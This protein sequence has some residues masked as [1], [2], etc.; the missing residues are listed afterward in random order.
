MGIMWTKIATQATRNEHRSPDPSR[1]SL[2]RVVIN[3]R[4]C[5]FG[6]WQENV[7]CIGGWQWL[8]DSNMRISLCATFMG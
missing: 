3:V 1:A 7:G 8:F 5:D 2:V 4:R 6:G